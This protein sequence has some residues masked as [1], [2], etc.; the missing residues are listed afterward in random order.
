MSELG[1]Q[2]GKK[3]DLTDDLI[4]AS[5]VPTRELKGKSGS[6]VASSETQVIA[7]AI[8]GSTAP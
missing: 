3:N 4:Q 5:V 1:K 8:L 6:L 7:A 2:E